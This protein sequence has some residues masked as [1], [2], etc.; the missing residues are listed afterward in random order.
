LRILVRL[1]T[2]LRPY[3]VRVIITALA[4]AG[5]MACSVTLPY[6]TRLVID[7]VLDGGREDLLLPIAAVFVGV[8]ALRFG[9]GMVRRNLAGQ[10]SLNVETDLRARMF[11]HLQ[12]L[13]VGYFD[14]MP[15]GQLMSRASTDLQTVRFFLGYGLVFL[16]MNA[17]TL[18]LVSALLFT[19]DVPLA[20][21]SLVVGP[22]LIAVAWRYSHVSNPVLADVQQRVGEVT[23]VAE[24]SIAGIRVVK[25]FGQEV[26]RGER[27]AGTARGAF[28]RSMDAAWIRASYQPLMG[29]V[30]LVGLAVV[31]LYGGFATIDGT[32]TLGE[33]VQFYLYLTLLTGPFRTLGMLVG[34][35]QRAIAGGRRIFEVLDAEPDVD[36]PE[37]AVPLPDGPGA[38]AL[39]GVTFR[40]GPEAPAALADVDLS[41]PGGATIA[42]IGPTGSGKTALTQLLPRFYDPESGRVLLD[43]ADVRDLSLDDLRRSIALVPQEPFLFSTSVRE[44]IAY[45]RPD[46]TDHDVEEAARA[47][48]AHAFIEDLPEGYETLVGERGYTLSGG[49]RQRIAIARAILADP[50]IL[51]LDEATA[52][53]DAATEAE[54]HAAL[55]RVS[56]GRTT[57]LIAHRLSTLNLADTLCVLEE[58][59][60]VA[61][62]THAEL[63]AAN[64][65]YREIHD[66]GLSRPAEEVAR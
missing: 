34:N 6:L 25:A 21:L 57:I 40:F 12:R 38:I 3:R 17:F 27:F 43:G 29:F 56:R 41:I 9:L 20:L 49:Q 18:V 45:G 66:H 54:I 19:I 2:F 47:A 13:S 30:P 48:Q 35:G 42:L 11:A 37:Q 50:R 51:V 53:V 65:L 10:I 8:V 59:R 31:L 36:D 4:A 32:I 23:A 24:E 14:R 63:Y 5:L 44:N 39:E 33:F 60:I 46:A 16:F 55:E 62:G 64:D 22:V 28:G 61:Q 15:V 58:G 7:D 52:S 26:P 1:L